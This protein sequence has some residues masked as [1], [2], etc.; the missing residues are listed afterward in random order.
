MHKV[1]NYNILKKGIHKY[2]IKY[3]NIVGKKKMKTKNNK[4]KREKG[5]NVSM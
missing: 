4:P 5:R 3:Y 2:K 1:I